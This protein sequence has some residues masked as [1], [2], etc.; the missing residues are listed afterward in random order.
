MERK[1]SRSSCTAKTTR[2]HECLL[3]D[4]IQGSDAVAAQ[5]VS[6]TESKQ[7]IL[8]YIISR[9][10]GPRRLRLSKWG[11]TPYYVSHPVPWE[12]G[13]P[14]LTSSCKRWKRRAEWCR[15]EWWGPSIWMSP[16]P[17]YSP[18]AHQ[19]PYLRCACSPSM[20]LHQCKTTSLMFHLLENRFGSPRPRHTFHPGPNPSQESQV[21]SPLRTI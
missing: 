20:T 15:E 18:R 3:I 21:A 12:E 16:R 1:K 4:N 11:G 5:V 6:K 13:S 8:K 19:A 9:H 17:D 10:C 2:P 7:E 14:C